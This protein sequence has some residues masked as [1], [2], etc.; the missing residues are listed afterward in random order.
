ML[1]LIRGER[2]LAEPLYQLRMATL[3]T[4]RPEELEDNRKR[5][6]RDAYAR[7][8]RYWLMFA[9]LF[10][11]P[12]SFLVSFSVSP[13]SILLLTVAGLFFCASMWRGIQALRY[14]PHVTTMR[15]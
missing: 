15:R 7:A 1:K 3:T 10:G 12:G 14:L 6:L 8:G 2:K 11:V 5:A 4:Q 13:L 9:T